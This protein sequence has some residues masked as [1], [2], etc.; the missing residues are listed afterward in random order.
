MKT[1]PE[2]FGPIFWT[3]LFTPL[4][5]IVISLLLLS[6]GCEDSE[7]SGTTITVEDNQAPVEINI[8]GG[9]STNEAL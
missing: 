8:Y 2:G 5:L 6:S 9:S 3:I 7:E 1:I 4:Y